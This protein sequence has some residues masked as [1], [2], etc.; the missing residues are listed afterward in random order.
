MNAYLDSKVLNPLAPMESRVMNI[1]MVGLP[2]ARPNQISSK[3][4]QLFVRDKQKKK[5]IKII[6]FIGNSLIF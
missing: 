3:W 2:E 1:S 6:K 4:Y 5:M